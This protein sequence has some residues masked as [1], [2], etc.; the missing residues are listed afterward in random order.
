[1]TIK[2]I[3][4]FITALMFFCGISS[5]LYAEFLSLSIGVPVQRTFT[6]EDDDGDVPEADSVSG[7]LIHASIPLFPGLGYEN[8]ENTFKD[9]SFDFKLK[10]EMYDIF[11]LFP[12]PVVNITA[13]LGIGKAELTCDLGSGASCSDYFESEFGNTSQWYLQAGIP[14]IPLFDI[15]LS[16][17]SITTK[18]EGKSGT[19]DNDYSGTMIAAG[20][21]FTF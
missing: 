9:D 19:K 18:I 3:T 20:A 5:S 11:Y 6:A 13:G 17:H 7:M 1:M 15:H 14:I 12:I 10:T 21:Q 2:K 8:Y 4:I 16:Y